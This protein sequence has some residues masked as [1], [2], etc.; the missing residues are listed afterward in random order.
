MKFQILRPFFIT[1]A[2]I[3]ML[4]G[5]AANR[6]LQS[7]SNPDIHLAGNPKFATE[8]APL[9]EYIQAII[10]EPF[11]TTLFPDQP[12]YYEIEL[13]RELKCGEFVDWVTLDRLVA[14]IRFHT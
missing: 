5:F 10:D 2:I 4:A 9:Q 7:T 14:T 6:F 11:R 13:D 8:R 3:F 12:A 1:A